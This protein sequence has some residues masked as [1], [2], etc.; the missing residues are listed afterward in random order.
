PDQILTADGKTRPATQPKPA[1]TLE[2]ADVDTAREFIIDALRKKYT[3]LARGQLYRDASRIAGASGIKRKAFDAALDAMIDAGSV[4]EHV[5]P[6][7]AREYHFADVVDRLEQRAADSEKTGAFSNIP[8]WEPSWSPMAPEPP[9]A[10]EQ[11]D[12]AEPE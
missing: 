6:H 5:N 3:P 12:E 8:K 10:T 11:G 7:G 4:K 1:A 2:V 9:A